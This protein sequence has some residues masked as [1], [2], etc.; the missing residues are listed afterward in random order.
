M[1]ERKLSEE[2]LDEMIADATVDAY[3]DYE[4]FMSMVCHLDSNMDF[5]FKAKVLDDI[6]EVVGIEVNISNQGRGVV[7]NVRK[8]GKI[9]TIGLAELTVGPDSENTEWIEMFHYWLERH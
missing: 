3:G 7:A 6:V 8:K 5:P 1:T 2:E 4:E 9:Y